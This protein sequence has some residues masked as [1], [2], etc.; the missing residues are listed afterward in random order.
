MNGVP[1]DEEEEVPTAVQSGAITRL[2]TDPF[3]NTSCCS[4]VQCT[5]CGH[6]RSYAT[7]A[8]E[9]GANGSR[10]TGAKSRLAALIRSA[11]SKARSASLRACPCT[12]GCAGSRLALRNAEAA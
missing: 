6:Q 4:S 3:F 7:Q 12:Q 9:P 2:T 5:S 1:S 11:R 8:N 10:R